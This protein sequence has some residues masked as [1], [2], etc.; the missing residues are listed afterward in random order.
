LIAPVSCVVRTQIGA[1]CC[2]FETNQSVHSVL[3]CS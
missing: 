3:R 2:Y 1:K